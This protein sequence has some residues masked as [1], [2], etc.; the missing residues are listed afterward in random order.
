M[1]GIDK[2]LKDIQSEIGCCSYHMESEEFRSL[3]KQ[4]F[5]D[6]GWVKINGYGAADKIK[7]ISVPT[8]EGPTLQFLSGQAWYDRLKKEFGF[9]DRVDYGHEKVWP[10]SAVVMLAK[11]A[12]G[13]SNE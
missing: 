3:I 11:K 10:E 6:D 12:A 5:I 8:Y 7:S 2:K 1:S 9:N 4:A 13:I